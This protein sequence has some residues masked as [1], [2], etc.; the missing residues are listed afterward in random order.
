MARLADQSYEV[1]PV[2]S[3]TQHPS[4]PNRGR[5][6]VIGE[7]VEAHGFYGAV[8]VQTSTRRILAGNHRWQAAKD[9]GLD[10]VPAVFVDVDDETAP[11]IMLADNRTTRL[12]EDDDAALAVLLQ[13]LA[14]TDLG[15]AGVGYDGSD[16]DELLVRV[17]AHERHRPADVDPDDVPPPPSEPV[18]RPGDVWLCGPHRIVCG[19]CRDA[20]VVDRV[21]AGARVNV[22]FTSP[23]YAD[24]RS[25]DESSGFQPVPPDQYA[26]W[27]DAAQA[28][29][30]AHLATDGSFFLNIKEHCED[31]QRV[32]YVK[33][34]TLA[35]VRQWDW[36]LVDEFVWV[37]SGVPGRWENRFKNGWEPVFHLCRQSTIKFRPDAV[38]HPSD[39]VLRYSPDN[40]KTHSGFLSSGIGDNGRISGMALPN[41]VLRINNARAEKERGHTAEFPVDLPSF[42]IQAYTDPGDVVLDPFLGSGT[43]IVA[44][45]LTGRVCV[46]IELSPAYCDVALTR[47]Q[48]VSGDKPI[49]ESTG[50]PHDFGR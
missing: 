9:A 30:A 35:F 5:L 33:D 3:L 46:G 24:R 22:A 34:L 15:L 36:R 21:L 40:P 19:D 27:F 50:V 48:A 12:G 28:N 13:Q 17:A 37:K 8:I 10:A 41:N 47:W 2:D 16:L 4:N 23:P 45:H 49:L 14:A 29:V 31:G 42:F 20:D 1:V 18:T 26:E 38:A 32:L 11:R 44:C 39:D 43:T 6:D 7:S 25:Y